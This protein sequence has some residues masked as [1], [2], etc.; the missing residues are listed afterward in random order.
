MS[1]GKRVRSD[2]LHAWVTDNSG[3]IAER[4]G[5]IGRLQ[6]PLVAVHGASSARHLDWGIAAIESCP[7]ME[8][9]WRNRG[10]TP[11]RTSRQHSRRLCELWHSS[12]AVVR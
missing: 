5:G 6:Q 12:K 8:K 10:F 4:R 9:L 1:V 11:K 3:K 7:K 2:D